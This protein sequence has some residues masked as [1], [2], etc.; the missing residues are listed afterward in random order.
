MVRNQ[1]AVLAAGPEVRDDGG[2]GVVVAREEEAVGRG[3]DVLAASKV[4]EDR[5][6]DGVAV[7][8]AAGEEVLRGR[9]EAC[10]GGVLDRRP[11]W[12]MLEGMLGFPLAIG[13]GF[14]SLELAS[15]S[16]S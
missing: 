5:D 1:S 10:D 13:Y 14:D 16:R 9:D 3:G 7:V 15:E 2:G 4:V 11:L 8:A 6:D 12:R